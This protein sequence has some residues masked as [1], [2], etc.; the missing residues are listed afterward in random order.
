MTDQPPI[1]TPNVNVPP[2][3]A[4]QGTNWK[5]WM[6]IGGGGCLLLV[7][8]L[9]IGFAGCLAAFSGS[10]GEDSSNSGE[11]APED[12]RKQAVPIGETVKAGDATWTITSATQATEI[13]AYPKKKTGNFVIV[14]LTFQNDSDEAMFVDSNSLAIIDDKGRTF[15]TDTDASIPPA[16]DLFIEQVN[17]GLTQQGRVI[18]ELAPDAKGLILRAGDTE[19]LSDEN[20]YINLGI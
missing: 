7:F 15:E 17:P 14:D 3:P 16:L 10:G 9:L 2:P 5:R 20:A 1:Q 18:F 6:F 11:Q 12:I 13:N 19:M 4:Q 8:L